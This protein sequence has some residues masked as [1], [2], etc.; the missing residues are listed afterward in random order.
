MK[1]ILIKKKEPVLLLQ[2]KRETGS[3]AE[4]NKDTNPQTNGSG[5]YIN[6]A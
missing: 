3:S 1:Y 4:E 5:T 2:S 6:H